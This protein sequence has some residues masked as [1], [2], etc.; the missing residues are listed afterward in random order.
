MGKK[1]LFA[2]DAHPILRQ[3]LESLGY[4][5]EEFPGYNRKDFED[6]I[7]EYTGIIIRSKFML[8]KTILD[9]AINLKF[10]GRVGSGM[11]SIDVDYARTKGIICLNSPEGN[12]D[13]VGEHALGMLLSLMNHLNRADREVREGKWKR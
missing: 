13:A 5:C 2:D 1:I 12:R 8:D 6:S 11:E 10:I 9:K 7:G 4:S 3:E